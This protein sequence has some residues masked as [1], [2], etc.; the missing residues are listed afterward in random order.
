M[1]AR[2]NGPPGI[3][4]P[5]QVNR[6]KWKTITT[7]VVY[8]DSGICHK[9]GHE[10]A[11]TADHLV[12][13]SQGGAAWDTA[14]LKAVHHSPCPTCRLRC[15]LIAVVQTEPSAAPNGDSYKA[16]WAPW[17]GPK[18]EPRPEEPGFSIWQL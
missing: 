8:R 3:R 12:P 16:P 11:K 5:S 14:N 10:G 6:T 18:S 2:V 4:H 7:A 17:F 9:C 13:V 1:T 15:N